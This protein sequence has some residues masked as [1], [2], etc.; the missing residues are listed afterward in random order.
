M[1]AHRTIKCLPDLSEEGPLTVEEF[2]D[3]LS[4]IRWDK[5]GIFWDGIGT[6]KTPRGA[7][8]VAGPKEV[9][10]AVADA[11]GGINER[12]VASDTAAVRPSPRRPFRSGRPT[13]R[14]HFARGGT[15]RRPDP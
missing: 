8:T 3:L 5:E 10:Y 4:D 14:F 15:A 12:A 6:R 13:S 11:I 9:G 1:A 7:I 2:L